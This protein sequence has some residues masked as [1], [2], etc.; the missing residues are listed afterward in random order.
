MATGLEI[1]GFVLTLMPLVYKA[2]IA[3]R[4][5]SGVLF[6]HRQVYKE[7]SREFKV[8]ITGFQN[9]LLRICGETSTLEELHQDNDWAELERRLEGRIR[10][11]AISTFNETVI[12]FHDTVQGLQRLFEEY[13]EMQVIG[14]VNG[15]DGV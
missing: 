2:A 14:I 10:K 5:T 3:C 9:T 7:F 12:L 4:D 8:E 15:F 13:A 1:A 6:H 11:E